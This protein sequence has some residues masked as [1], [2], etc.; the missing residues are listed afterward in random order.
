MHKRLLITG[1]TGWVGTAFIDS[2]ISKLESNE[3][4][5]VVPYS[6]SGS[7]INLSNEKSIQSLRY[8]SSKLINSD[9]D[10]FVPAAFLTR[11]YANDLNDSDY[12]SINMKLIS[13]SIQSIETS[14]FE[15]IINFSSGVV[16]R[17]SEKQTRS[18]SYN[19]YRD[20]KK[21]QEDALADAASRLGANFI[22]CRIF[23]ISGKFNRN[24]NKYAFYNLISQAKSGKINIDSNNHVYRKFMDVSD[25]C[26]LL[27]EAIQDGQ[28]ESFE[29]TGELIELGDLAKAINLSFGNNVD[30]VRSVD[31]DGAIDE[32]Y[33][34][35]GKLDSFAKKKNY[36]MMSLQEQIQTSKALLSQFG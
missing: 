23:S 21:Y 6:N 11:D 31:F 34:I 27:I 22:N 7:E 4:Y 14:N 15:T 25:L 2:F 19:T 9:A 10:I 32:Y 28:E 33:S 18:R 20:L 12:K 24:P 16:S 13:E 36:R 17:I 1:A 35:D 29:S 3:S 26:N 5:S 30:I 8:E